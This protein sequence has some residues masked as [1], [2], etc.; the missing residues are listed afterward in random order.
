M[1]YCSWRSQVSSPV[2]SLAESTTTSYSPTS[3]WASTVTPRS[4]GARR[5]PLDSRRGDGRL[6][7]HTNP[8]G[9]EVWLDRYVERGR[10][11]VPEPVRPL[12]PTPLVEV[13]LPMGSYRLRIQGKAKVNDYVSAV[14]R[15]ASGE[16][17][18]DDGD[19]RSTN[20]TLG[21]DPDFRKDDISIDLAY[22]ERKAPSSSMGSP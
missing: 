20:R 11:L 17:I 2:D 15:L 9:A 18:D 22:I 6:T 19:Q 3:N 12:G 8:P 14:F 1:L 5:R 16:Q 21:R 10:R 13:P 4:R 7:L